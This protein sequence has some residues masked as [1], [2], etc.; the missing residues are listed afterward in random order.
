MFRKLKKMNIFVFFFTLPIYCR[1]LSTLSP[2][3]PIISFWTLG[4]IFA[5][6][7]F[8]TLVF[9]T[10]MPLIVTYFS[11]H[12]TIW[13]FPDLMA[14]GSMQKGWLFYIKTAPIPS[15]EASHSH[16][17]D[18]EKS[19]KSNTGHELI[20]SFIFSNVCCATSNQLNAPFLVSSMRGVVICENPLTYLL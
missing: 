1:C 17:K 8:V 3:N 15:P 13:G 2:I 9:S 6:T 7:I 19:G 4:D 18:W 14:N 5:D 10:S 16:T 12:M 20:T 11:I